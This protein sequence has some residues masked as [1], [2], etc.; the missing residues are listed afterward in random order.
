MAF[1][2]KSSISEAG[3]GER[4]ESWLLAA[5]LAL[6]SLSALTPQT[7][8]SSAALNAALARTVDLPRR[9]RATLYF[10]RSGGLSVL[11][12]LLPAMP[13]ISRSVA[14]LS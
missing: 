9:V 1:G 7:H 11:K 2:V 8:R 13:N 10:R 4:L 12:L 14:N 3:C 5:A 6:V